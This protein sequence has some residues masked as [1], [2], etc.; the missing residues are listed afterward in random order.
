MFLLP[1]MMMLSCYYD[2][3]GLLR[4]VMLMMFGQNKSFYSILWK[5]C[6]MSALL[7]AFITNDAACVVITPLLL[8]EFVKPVHIL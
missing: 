8:S 7:S 6:L 3:E 5:V 4:V 1:D 2:R